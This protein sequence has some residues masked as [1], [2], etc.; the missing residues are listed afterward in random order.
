MPGLRFTVS[1]PTSDLAPQYA[2]PEQGYWYSWGRCESAFHEMMPQLDEEALRRLTGLR[3]LR[4]HGKVA[5]ADGMIGLEIPGR[6]QASEYR[7]VPAAW[8]DKTDRD[9]RLNNVLD[10]AREDVLAIR[11]EKDGNTHDLLIMKPEATA[12]Y[13]TLLK[14]PS[15]EA[16]KLFQ[17]LAPA[18]RV[19]GYLPVPAD[20]GTSRSLI[21]ADVIL[22][23][24]GESWPTDEEDLMEP[25]QK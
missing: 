10:W 4:V 16:E 12:A 23:G 21:V 7:D 25:E 24:E 2:P 5:G 1:Q 22:S 14:E 6:K 8:N 20:Q 13:L 19:V 3:G 17:T 15:A 18:N 9:A 11:F